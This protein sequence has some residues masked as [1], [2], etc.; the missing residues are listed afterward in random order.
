MVQFFCCWVLLGPHVF[1]Q[2]LVLLS[3]S[4]STVFSFVCGFGIELEKK[5]L[6][7]CFCKFCC[8]FT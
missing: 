3:L 1:K 6:K 8:I 5:P 7:I 4:A 2:K